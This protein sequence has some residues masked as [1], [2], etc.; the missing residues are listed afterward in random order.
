MT[1]SSG[2]PDDTLALVND[3]VECLLAPRIGGS[4]AR[5]RWRGGGGGPPLD[6]L[7]PVSDDRLRHG[8]AED[9]GCFPLVPFSNRIADGRF[10]FDDREVRL[11]LN[12]AGSPH[13][14][15]GH[16]WRSPWSVEER[17]ATTARLDYRHAADAWPWRYRATQD[18]ALTSD[19][20]TITIELSNEGDG[21]MPAGLGLHPYF[22]KPPGTTLRARLSGLWD[23]DA[24]LLP[25]VRRPLPDGCDFSNGV[26]MDRTVF[27]NGF[28]GWNGAATLTWPDVGLRLSITADDL[29]GH[30][31]IYSPAGEEYLC[32]EPVSHMTDAVNRAGEPESGLRVLM[33]GERLS[34]TVRFRVEPL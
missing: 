12:L 9:L 29:F 27:D 3:T 2:R 31:V 10:R 24:T 14:I 8:G 1:A 6:L 28:T 21:P 5:L 19:G 32:V 15:H 16:G 7:R 22:R 13:A 18:V 23:N 33:P 20:V 26:T 17:T 11:P 34:G 30:L 4:V 25:S